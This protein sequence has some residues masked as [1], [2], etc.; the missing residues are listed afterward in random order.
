ML[1][2]YLIKQYMKKSFIELTYYIV[3]KIAIY[4]YKTTIFIYESLLRMTDERFKKNN[5]N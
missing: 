3:I 2:V 1:I 4:L 5:R